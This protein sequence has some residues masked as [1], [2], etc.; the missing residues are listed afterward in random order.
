MVMNSMTGIQVLLAE[1]HEIVR[2]GYMKVLKSWRPNIRFE[3]AT[4]YGETYGKVADQA[5]DLVIL[6]LALPGRCGLE[7]LNDMNHM[8][9]R[10]RVLASSSYD[11]SKFGV[12]ALRSGASGYVCKE[13]GVTV[14]LQAVDAV[15]GGRTFLSPHLAQ[16][17]VQTVQQD[18]HLKGHELLSDR[19]F[20]ILRR[21]ARGQCIKEIAQSLCLS[22]KTVS[23]HRSHL[24]VT[25]KVDT[26]AELVQYA[27]KHGLVED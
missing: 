14:F 7:L 27:I 21:L 6:E 3:H 16:T 15:L 8:R 22:S 1:P 5:W 9:S 20:Q 26:L 24:M 25:L 4:N 12:R 19:E 18:S 23:S 13:Q 2:E 10:P 17:L 11:E